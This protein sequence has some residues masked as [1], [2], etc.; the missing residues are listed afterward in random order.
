LTV[1]GQRVLD[2]AINANKG[3]FIT[4]TPA[5]NP[6]TNTDRKVINTGNHTGVSK[7]IVNR[8]LFD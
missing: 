3:A 8:K 2:A 4:S 5:I 1:D 7:Q 6:A